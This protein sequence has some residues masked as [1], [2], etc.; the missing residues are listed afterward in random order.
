MG[1][2][3][4]RGMRPAICP[5]LHSMDGAG[6]PIA[7]LQAP[8]GPP[9]DVYSALVANYNPT[10]EVLLRMLDT[11]VDQFFGSANDLVVPSEGGWRIDQPGRV[12]IPAARIGCFGPGG[13]LPAIR[14]RTSTSSAR[15]KR[16][17]F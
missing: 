9:A 12:F 17:T 16:W 11:G 1:S 3:G 15:P 6:D 10:R 8:P 2:Y 14:S 5:G 7:E 13:N 4:S